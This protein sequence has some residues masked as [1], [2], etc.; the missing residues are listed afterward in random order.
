MQ[1]F[2][3][4]RALVDSSAEEAFCLA[5]DVNAA[6]DEFERVEARDTGEPFGSYGIHVAMVHRI[7]FGESGPVFE[8]VTYQLDERRWSRAGFEQCLGFF[9]SP[10]KA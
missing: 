9:K 7:A 5:A 6:M 1:H 3:R 4:V 2:Y 8:D 10:T